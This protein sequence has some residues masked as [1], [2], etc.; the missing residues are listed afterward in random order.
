[1]SGD[2]PLMQLAPQGIGPGMVYVSA[3]VRAM[4]NAWMAERFGMVD[5]LIEPDGVPT[6]KCWS[7][8]NRFDWDA[9]PAEYDRNEAGSNM[10]GGTQWC[11][12]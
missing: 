7:C 11:I 10:C 2:V 3:S 12:P 4:M 6:V 8:G 1:M 5:G 9:D